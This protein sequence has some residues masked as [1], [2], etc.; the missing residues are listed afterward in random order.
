MSTASR[1]STPLHRPECRAPEVNGPGCHITV[2]KAV[3]FKSGYAHLHGDHPTLPP[4]WDNKISSATVIS[5]LWQIHTER[6][7]RGTNTVISHQGFS[8]SAF[9]G[10]RLIQHTPGPTSRTFDLANPRGTQ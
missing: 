2:H 4:D 5:G 8:T 9:A 6:N 10:S 3:N 7:Y 1:F